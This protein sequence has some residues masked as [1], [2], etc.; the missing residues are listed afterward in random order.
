MI[1]EGTEPPLHGQKPQPGP[2]N[3]P[4]TSRI[5]AIDAP[6]V[7]TGRLTA[8]NGL[9]GRVEGAAAAPQNTARP[10]LWQRAVDVIRREPPAL[11]PCFLHRD[12]HPGN[13]L[14]EGE[15]DDVRISGVVD[16]VETSWGPADLDV[17]HCSTAL[18]LLHGVSL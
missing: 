18:A 17:A 6:P 10:E 15:G 3:P 2:G 13:V 7:T 8:A 16:W 12:F 5:P 14:F 1:A 4:R 9:E 11:R